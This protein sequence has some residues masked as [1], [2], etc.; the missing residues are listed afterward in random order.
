MSLYLYILI[1]YIRM[2]NFSQFQHVACNTYYFLYK[3]LLD[4]ITDK[5][6]EICINRNNIIY[7]NI[8]RLYNLL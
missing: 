8:F 6:T 2:L 3:I 5:F 7:Y 1:Y 4:K